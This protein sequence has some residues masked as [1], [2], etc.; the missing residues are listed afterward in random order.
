MS[1]NKSPLKAMFLLHKAMMTSQMIF[2]AIATVLVFTKAFYPSL[3][4]QERIFQVIALVLCFIGVFI[5]STLFKRSI[6]SI[7]D[8][9]ANV[10]EK[11]E[12]Y[13][14]AALVQWVLLEG[15]VLF[16]I[17][18]FMLTAS[19]SLLILAIVLMMVFSAAAPSK[20]K[21]VFLLKLKDN[22]AADI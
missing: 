12:Q 3:Q 18:A 16:V 6:S 5:G 10:K 15:P 7:R 13:G 4:E 2:A 21:I 17:I 9:N 20:S 14:K 1:E 8:S 22:E 19:Y 11:V